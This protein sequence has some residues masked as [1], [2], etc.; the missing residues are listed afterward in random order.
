M[1]IV[2]ASKSP[3]RIALLKALG[4]TFEIIP[5]SVDES[6]VAAG[7]P[8][9]IA[10]EAARLKAEE[11]AA[12]LDSALVIAADTIVCRG[13]KIYGKPKS[14]EEARET[15]RELSGRMHRV[16]TGLALEETGHSDVAPSRLDAEETQVFFKPLDDRNIDEYIATGEPF[17]K[18]G[19]YGIQGA[20]SSLVERI[21]GCYFN[22]V[23]LPLPRLLKLLSSFIDISGLNLPDTPANYK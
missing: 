15:L 1:R 19:G 2:L 17:D 5:S 6:Q 23:G 4:L 11:V 8:R 9:E 7:S 16:I 10:T 3:R 20:G 21:E 12:R 18:A 22:V 13:D 14:I